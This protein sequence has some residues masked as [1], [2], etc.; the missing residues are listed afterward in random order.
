MIGEMME[1]Q[2]KIEDYRDEIGLRV[3]P[4]RTQNFANKRGKSCESYR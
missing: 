3:N 4:R 1:L 2:K